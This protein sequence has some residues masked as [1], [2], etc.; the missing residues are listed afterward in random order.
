MDTS[1]SGRRRHRSWPE[2]L[3]REIVAASFEPGSSVSLVARRYDLNTNQLFS[4]RKQQREE[5]A[6]AEARAS[7]AAAMIVHLKLMIAKLRRDQYG[8]SSE[9]GRKVIDQLELQLEEAEVDAAERSVVTEPATPGSA[10]QGFTRRRPVRAPLPA[11]L[12]RE[13]VVIPAPCACPACGGKLS[14]LGEDVTAVLG[15]GLRC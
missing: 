15:G 1:G 8:Q 4:W 7:G 10:V 5:L 14:K 12:P 9:R 6:L 2:T 11:H 3:K 13:R